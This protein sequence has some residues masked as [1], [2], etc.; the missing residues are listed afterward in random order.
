MTALFSNQDT[1]TLSEQYSKIVDELLRQSHKSFDLAQTSLTLAQILG[2][3]SALVFLAGVCIM[4]VV[5]THQELSPLLPELSLAFAAHKW[6]YMQT[7]CSIR[8]MPDS[9]IS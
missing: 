5:I 6:L 7:K 9:T 8:L 1:D 3:L 2:T 4:F